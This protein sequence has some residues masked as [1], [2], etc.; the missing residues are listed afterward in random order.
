MIDDIVVMENGA[1]KDVV[2]INSAELDTPPEGAKENEVNGALGEWGVAE[3]SGAPGVDSSLEVAAGSK[4]TEVR[5]KKKKRKKKLCKIH[6][7][8][9]TKTNKRICHSLFLPDSS[10]IVGCSE[11]LTIL[12]L[13]ESSDATFVR[14]K[15]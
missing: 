11:D 7:N 15:G 9:K 1:M 5:K 4:Q 10:I 14:S 12:Y 6:R 3:D 8:T 2:V 13:I